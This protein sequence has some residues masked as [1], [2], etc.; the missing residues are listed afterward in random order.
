MSENVG[1]DVGASEFHVIVLSPAG[2]LVDFPRSGWTDVHVLTGALADQWADST[3]AIDAPLRTSEGLLRSEEYR[4]TVDPPPPAGKYL[5]YR[6]CDYQLI[7]RR[8]PLYQVPTSYQQC[9]TWMQAGFKLYDALLR[10]GNWTIFDGR[11]GRN[12]LLE[13]YPFACFSALLGHI[14]PRKKTVAGRCARLAALD[15]GLGAGWSAAAALADDDEVDAAV[16]A[17]TALRFS[18]GEAHWVGNPREALMVIP[19]PLRERYHPGD[20]TRSTPADPAE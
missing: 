5:N 2:A 17:L 20:S 9:H 7:R 11:P 15:A 12:R 6:E 13:V 19:A 8:L 10:T 18:R 14:P 16:G 4:A 3:I 1:I